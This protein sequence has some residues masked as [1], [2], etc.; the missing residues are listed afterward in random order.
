MVWGFDIF[1]RKMFNMAVK[2]G[3]LNVRL[4]EQATGAQEKNID[5]EIMGKIFAIYKRTK[6]KNNQARSVSATISFDGANYSLFL[7]ENK[8]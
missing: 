5:L 6:K 3:V 8:G 1:N 2:S 4:T 7:T